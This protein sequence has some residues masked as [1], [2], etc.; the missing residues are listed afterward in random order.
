MSVRALFLALITGGVIIVLCGYNPFEAFGAIAVGA[1]GSTRALTQTL[2]QATP[3]IFTG[4]AFTAAKK[5][6]LINLGIEGQLQAGAMMAAVV[7]LL[8]LHLPGIIWI[9]FALASAA[10][11]G[12]LYAGLVGF[13]KVRF[14]SNEVIA[15]IMLNTIALNVASYLVNYPL[16]AEGSLA[17]SEKVAEAV[18]LPRIFPKYQLTVA[19]FIAIFSCFAFKY[20]Q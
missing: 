5:A 2:I 4:L 3:L 7:G 15:T 17:Q 6:S 8:P 14:G 1:F 9:P 11:A 18:F 20:F 12:G 19:V 10:I 13:L 16:K